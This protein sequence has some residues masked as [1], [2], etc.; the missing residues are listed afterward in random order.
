MWQMPTDSDQDKALQTDGVFGTSRLVHCPSFWIHGAGMSGTTWGALTSLLPLAQTPDLPWHGSA[1]KIVPPT[2]EAFADYL[3]P[4]L[5]SGTVLIGHSLGGMV[6][7]ELA[8]RWPEKIEALVLIESVPTARGGLAKWVTGGVARLFVR[9]IPPHW[10]AW[11]SGLGQEEDA[12]LEMK[13]QLMRHTKTS[14]AAIMDAAV[15]YDGRNRLAQI[16][17]PT[18]I[19]VGHQNRATHGGAQ[20]ASDHIPAATLIAL[21]G[22]HMLYK[23]NPAQVLRAIDDFLASVPPGAGVVHTDAANGDKAQ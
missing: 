16:K 19:I 5:P 3:S 11:L 2:V 8:A 13:T 9:T 6:A 17:A 10:L 20:Y 7:M 15:A 1:A 22:G 12:R 4:K 14:L 21:A 18:L 23:D